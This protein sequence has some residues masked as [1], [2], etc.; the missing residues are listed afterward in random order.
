M[1]QT[2]SF[3]I[4]PEDLDGGGSVTIPAF[5][6]M[7]ISSVGWDIRREGFGVDVMARRGLT[8]VLARCAFEFIRRPR[9]YERVDVHIWPSSSDRLLQDRSLRASGSD[10]STICKGVTQWCVLE[11]DTHRPVSMN[12]PDGEVQDMPCTPPLR[13]S[14][15][16]PCEE[17]ERQVGYSECDFNGHLNNSRYVE[18][19]FDL[20][21][22]GVAQALRPLRLDVNFKKE[23]P[24]GGKILSSI[25]QAGES[26]FSFLMRHE[27]KAACLASL[28]LL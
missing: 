13:M 9:L 21:P 3:T 26:A 7:L 22:S 27:G 25:R 4:C 24:L 8:W 12:M 17:H 14:A 23:I 16:S 2:Y 11:K 6:R 1:S 15:F 20:L 28:V 18:M 5:Y 19:F 10:G